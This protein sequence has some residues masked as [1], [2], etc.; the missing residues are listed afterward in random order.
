MVTPSLLGF[1]KNFIFFVLFL[2]FISLS[3]FP[4]SMPSSVSLTLGSSDKSGVVNGLG[5][6]CPSVLVLGE[7]TTLHS[8]TLL[9]DLPFEP[10]K[11]L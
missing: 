5:T 7:P 2:S 10:E 3:S 4:L 11:C 6:V 8:L 1:M 9:P